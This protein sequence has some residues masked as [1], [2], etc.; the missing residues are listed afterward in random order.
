MRRRRPPAKLIKVR[1]TCGTVALAGR[2]VFHAG[3]ARRMAA[4]NRV[5]TSAVVRRFAETRAARTKEPLAGTTTADCSRSE[6]SWAGIMAADRKV[7][8]VRIAPMGIDVV[9]KKLVTGYWSLI[10][11]H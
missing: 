10:I 9:G 4:M 1:T 11:G 7:E 2:N 3:L 5:T 6:S 8:L